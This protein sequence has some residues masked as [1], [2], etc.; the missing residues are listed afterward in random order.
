MAYHTPLRRLIIIIAF[1]CFV[2]GCGSGESNTNNNSST[3][4]NNSNLGNGKP[5]S[6][7]YGINPTVA[8][9]VV[10]N[11]VNVYVAWEEPFGIQPSIV[12]RR[13]IDGGITFEPLRHLHFPVVQEGSHPVLAA[14]GEDVYLVWVGEAGQGY[15][16]ILFS[17]S[18]S[19]GQLNPDKSDSFTAPVSVSGGGKTSV[20]PTL[21]V[22]P[23]FVYVAW[24]DLD[25]GDIFFRRSDPTGGE[26]DD[27]L[28]AHPIL[29]LSNHG[30]ATSAANPSVSTANGN[31]YV[32]WDDALT[33][34][35]G[36]NQVEDI[37]FVKSIDEGQNF[38]QSTNLSSNLTNSMHPVIAA[39]DQNVYVVWEDFSSSIN[40]NSILLFRHS[41]DGGVTF[42]TLPEIPLLG[43]TTTGPRM[44]ADDSHVFIVWPDSDPDL[45]TRQIFLTRSSNSGVNFGIPFDISQNPQSSQNPS[46]AAAQG[47][48]Y[49]VWE[50]QFETS[51]QDFEQR[52]F[53]FKP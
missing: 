17:V 21:A 44:A 7:N 52:I 11:H 6:Q 18:H 36:G 39:N 13:S 20:N 43:A 47:N 28:V 30:T 37:L 23:S 9:S 45:G 3:N 48:A 29:N 34:N 8:A 26:F 40:S 35:P 32:A 2:Y 24:L 15:R 50:G 16:E 42:D 51:P 12:F 14:V 46:V 10:G 38:S 49:V 53:F 4:P 22:S 41:S 19:A 1:V 27:D 31:V 33:N 25:S 5:L